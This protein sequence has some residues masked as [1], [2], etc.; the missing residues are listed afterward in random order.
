MQRPCSLLPITGCLEFQLAQQ[1]NL[2]LS[3]QAGATRTPQEARVGCEDQAAG[4]HRATS[5]GMGGGWGRTQRGQQG[6]AGCGWAGR[7]KHGSSKPRPS[8]SAART[9][10]CPRSHTATA[11]HA[12][13]PSILRCTLPWGATSPEKGGHLT[14]R[15]WV[16][17]AAPCPVSQSAGPALWETLKASSGTWVLRQRQTEK[18]A[19]FWMK[20]HQGGER[21]W[22]VWGV[23]LRQGQW[24]AA[25]RQTPKEYVVNWRMCMCQG[26]QSSRKALRQAQASSV[27]G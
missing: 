19:G 20:L 11:P 21:M 5:S 6:C 24:G 7:Q 17:E 1:L 22:R 12:P 3:G 10:R 16:G 18:E 27:C 9:R 13:R 15:G 26:K 25:P 14:S 2:K 23:T 4:H 8:Q